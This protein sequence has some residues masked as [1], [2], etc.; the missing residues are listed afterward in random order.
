MI[1]RS[2]ASK[3]V[4]LPVTS[5]VQNVASRAPVPGGGSVAALEGSLGAGLYVMVCR[6]SETRVSEADGGYFR[7][8]ANAGMALRDRLR[9]LVDA[10]SDAYEEVIGAARLPEDTEEERTEKSSRLEKA[11]RKAAG[12]PFETA[13]ACLDGLKWGEELAGKCF[14]GAV[15]DVGVGAQSLLSGY[16]AARL[17]VLVNL[18]GM[19]DEKEAGKMR[20]FLDENLAWAKKTTEA[21]LDIV[22]KRIAG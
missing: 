17:N 5:F 15:T 19:N 11:N 6:L 12:V 21:V 7:E 16:I 13:S 1:E 9:G 20:S 10:D 4:Y 8:I 22:E 3:L 18:A 2:K 14:E